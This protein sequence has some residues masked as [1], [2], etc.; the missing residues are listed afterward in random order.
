M[1]TL[2]LVEHNSNWQDQFE[3]EIAKIIALGNLGIIAAY[4]IGSTAIAAIKAKPVI[5]MML[6]VHDL[7]VIDK[8]NN[9]FEKRG[10][11]PKGEFGTINRRFFQKGESK[12]TH[13]IHIF[14]SG[15]AELER[16]HLFVE[17]MNFFP[18]KALEYENLKV[19]LM[20]KY[21]LDPQLYSNGKS[22]FINRIDTEATIWKRTQLASKLK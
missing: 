1:R 12:R 7:E 3:T 19:M 14:E 22:V 15:N 5:D 10:Y 21:A 13:H 16:H 20:A 8:H 17:F 6:E 9:D 18:N 11:E 4:H 2:G